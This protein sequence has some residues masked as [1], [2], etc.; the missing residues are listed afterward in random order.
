[1][2]DCANCRLLAIGVFFKHQFVERGINNETT[3][4]ERA[5]LLF[6]HGFEFGVE[7]SENR[8]YETVRLEFGPLP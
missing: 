6:I 7:D 5:I 3:I 1:M 4:I 8:I 2:F